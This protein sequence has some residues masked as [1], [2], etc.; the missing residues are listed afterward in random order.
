MK[1]K[2]E[3]L[4]IYERITNQ[5]VTAIEK[6]TDKWELPWHRSQT[7]PINAATRK[8]YRGINVLALWAT[9][10]EKG[11]QSG[12]WATYAQWQ[13]LGA[14]VRKGEKSGFIVFW[15]FRDQADE[16]EDR[17]DHEEQTARL[18]PIARGYNVFNADQVDGFT[19][20][21]LPELPAAK[22]IEAADNFISGVDPDVRYGGNRAF[23][24][25]AGDYIQMPQFQIFKEATGFYSTLAHELVHNA[26]TRVMPHA[27]EKVRL[28]A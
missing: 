1:T 15:K 28:A 13:E 23:Y 19:L 5:I 25:A 6:G 10:A 17:E 7:I 26:V 27:F 16:K 11:Y 22:R 12:I 4:D 3:R 9:A 8:E 20:P 21:E 14:Q 2:E 24:S 18:G